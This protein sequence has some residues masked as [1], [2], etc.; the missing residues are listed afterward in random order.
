MSPGTASLGKWHFH[1]DPGERKAHL[2]CFPQRAIVMHPGLSSVWPATG[3]RDGSLLWLPSVVL[4][5]HFVR[6]YLHRERQFSKCGP[7]S[8]CVTQGSSER[9]KFLQ[10]SEGMKLHQELL[11]PGRLRPSIWGPPPSALGK[12]VSGL[13]SF[14]KRIC[15]ILDD[16]GTRAY[17]KSATRQTISGQ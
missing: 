2:V 14:N 15:Q 8:S 5:A 7:W 13:H 1:E 9:C 4:G 11:Q 12:S 3:P 10:D 16:R 17:T 6:F